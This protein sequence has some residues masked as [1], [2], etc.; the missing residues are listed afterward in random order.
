M[1]YAEDVL[2]ALLSICLVLTVLA[3]WGRI[4]FTKDYSTFTCRTARLS[5]KW[6]HRD[7]MRWRLLRARAAW[8]DS[9][10]VIRNGPVSLRTV[11]IAVSL[12][13]KARIEEESPSTVRLL[14]SCPQS[15]WIERDDGTPIKIAARKRDRTK[16]A[17]PFL[18]VAIAGLPAARREHRR[19]TP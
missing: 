19:R 8:V 1:R 5:T 15:L 13:A 2:V 11:T 9:V 12:P 6:W 3:L 14:G 10:L 4:R 17:G 16:L 18:A 7:G